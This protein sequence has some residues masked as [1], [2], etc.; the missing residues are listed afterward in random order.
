MTAVSV[1]DPATGIET[2]S[3]VLRGPGSCVNVMG[4]VQGGEHSYGYRIVEAVATST[5]LMLLIPRSM[6]D[7]DGMVSGARG[8]A[9]SVG[10][11][12]SPG[13]NREYPVSP[14]MEPGSPSV[15]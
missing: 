2:Q 6:L 1:T 5:C 8:R 7:S 12:G 3:V 14:S 13:T 10:G 4:L 11:S 15:D 9:G